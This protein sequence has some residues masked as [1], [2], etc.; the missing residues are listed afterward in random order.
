MISA[1]SCLAGPI[2]S[3]E[4]RRRIKAGLGITGLVTSS[5]EEFVKTEQLYIEKKEEWTQKTL[6]PR[7]ISS[8]SK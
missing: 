8:E 3:T 6:E 1:A 7:D 2:S 4:I 5:V